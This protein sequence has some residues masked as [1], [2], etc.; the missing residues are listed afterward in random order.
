MAYNSKYP[1]FFNLLPDVEVVKLF[2]Q[3]PGYGSVE[4][5]RAVRLSVAWCDDRFKNHSSGSGRV[6]YRDQVFGDVCPGLYV[7]S[8]LPIFFDFA[9][10][11]RGKLLGVLDSR[12]EP[13]LPS[14]LT[15]PDFQVGIGKQSFSMNRPL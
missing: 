8:S 9:K 7:L 2:T 11:R 14:L 6:V 13:F 5:P 4:K 15:F 12:G 3:E 10:C 1:T